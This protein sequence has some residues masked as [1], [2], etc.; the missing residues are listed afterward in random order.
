MSTIMHASQ[1]L[2]SG[3]LIWNIRI[4]LERNTLRQC[5]NLNFSST[6]LLKDSACSE[7]S[8]DRVKDLVIQVRGTCCALLAVDL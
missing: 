3:L 2:G 5:G 7:E 4:S 6:S 8:P 1:E